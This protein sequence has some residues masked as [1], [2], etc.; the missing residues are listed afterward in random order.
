MKTA[1]CDRILI[2]PLYPQYAA[3]T[4]ATAND[5]AFRALAAMRW[6]PAIRTLPPYHDDPAYIDALAASL[7]AS[8]AEL[9]FEPE[10]VLAS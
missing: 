5:D 10:L 4:T 6:Q 7:K 3:A 1:G 2:A 8:L 9:P